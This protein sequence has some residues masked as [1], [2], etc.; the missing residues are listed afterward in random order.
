VTGPALRRCRWAATDPLLAAYHDAEWGYPEHDDRALWEKLML[1]GFQAGLA[2][3]TILRK[4]E[5]FRAAFADFDPEAVARF[6]EADVVRLANDARIVRSRAKIAATIGN[7]RAV[8]AMA[9]SGE[10]FA[11]FVWG[12][13]GGAPIVSDGRTAR[14]R[15]PES[16]ALSAALRTRGFTFVGPVITYAWMQACGLVDDH[17]ADCF[18]RGPAGTPAPALPVS[19]R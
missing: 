2:W 15:S 6:G 19:A 4:R 12:F 3:I 1:D 5:A 10:A 13:V 11:P 18:R 7:A 16:E 14:T 17:E 9:A 8:L